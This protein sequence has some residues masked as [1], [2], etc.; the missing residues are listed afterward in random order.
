MAG[1]IAYVC[2][3]FGGP[4][5]RARGLAIARKIREVAEAHAAAQPQIW[6]RRRA[7]WRGCNRKSKS[8]SAAAAKE[9]AAESE[10]I[11]G[12]TRAD[13][14]KIAIAAQAEIDAA[15][16]AGR[17]ELR[18]IAAR[19]ATERAEVLLRQRRDA[20][21]QSRLFRAFVAQLPRTAQ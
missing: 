6:P 10:R 4:F 15:E 21:S 11:A 7:S 5:F 19:M 3:K 20:A 16:R 9:S 2:M 14:A 8:C 1:T 17:H 12:L 18:A 13:A